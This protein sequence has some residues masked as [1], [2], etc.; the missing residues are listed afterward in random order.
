MTI[1]RAV[2]RRSVRA[3][4]F[5]DHDRL[6]LIKRTKPGQPPYWT[7]AGGAV[8]LDDSS[9]ESALQRELLEEL[10]ARIVVGPQVFLTSTGNDDLV[11]VQHFFVCRVINVDPSLRTGPE[12]TDPTRGGYHLVRALPEQL[13]ML[14][15][16]PGKL[17]A[18]LADNVDAMLSEAALLG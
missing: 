9:R 1:S 10:G 7:T 4:L 16:K 8:E 17:R 13:A 5:D 12:H 2:G 11:D 18:F 14:D 15:I 6:L 3:V